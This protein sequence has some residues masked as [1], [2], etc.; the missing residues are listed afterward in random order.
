MWSVSTFVLYL[1]IGNDWKKK[2]PHESV[3]SFRIYLRGFFFLKSLAVYQYYCTC[4]GH[5]QNSQCCLKNAWWKFL[6]LNKKDI[7]LCLSGP[8]Q[9]IWK[10]WRFNK[11]VIE[12]SPK[13]YT[14]K[15]KK[16]NVD[17][18]LNTLLFTDVLTCQKSWI[19]NSI[20]IIERERDWLCIQE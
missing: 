18:P 4:K 12:F 2:L 14:P 9:K 5:C 11:W 3:K 6:L 17:K 20:E 13:K 7:N 16:K 1:C 19:K 15:K 10:L 8:V